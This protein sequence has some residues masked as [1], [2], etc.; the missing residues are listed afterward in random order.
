MQQFGEIESSRIQVL[1]EKSRQMDIKP[2][3]L[4]QFRTKSQARRALRRAMHQI[5]NMEVECRRVS[6]VDW[7]FFKCQMLKKRKLLL[8]QMAPT[9]DEALVC[10]YLAQYGEIRSLV[11]FDYKEQ[12][13]GEHFKF[14][15]VEFVHKKS[16]SLITSC[17]KEFR[18]NQQ[19]FKVVSWAHRNKVQR[20]L[21]TAQPDIDTL[22]RE[23]KHMS[24]EKWYYKSMKKFSLKYSE[25]LAQE[26]KKMPQ[27]VKTDE[28]STHAL[29]PG[30]SQNPQ[31]PQL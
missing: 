1:E 9:V 15:F 7:F 18:L 5:N 29:N 24:E 13:S 14:G 17:N 25:S 11:L 6:Q 21:Q 2:Y 23:L 20:F 8:H 22:E 27:E 3:A 16:V 30:S 19:K 31:E 26:K 10:S 4:V 28:K 12:Y